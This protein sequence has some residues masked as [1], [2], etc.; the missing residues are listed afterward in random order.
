M[1]DMNRI[2]KKFLALKKLKQGALICYVVGGYPD[3]DTTREVIISLVNGGTDIIEIGIPFSD[4]IA[5][6]PV[7]QKA[8]TIALSNNITPESCLELA[9]SVRKIFP[10]LPLIFMTYSNILLRKGFEQ[11]MNLSKAAGIDGFIIPDLIIEEANDYLKIA[12]DLNLATIFLISPN[13][14]KE[15]IRRISEASKGFLYLVSVFGTTGL[16]KKFDDHTVAMIRLIKQVTDN[17]NVAVGFG[18][19]KQSHVKLMINSGADGVIVGSAIVNMIGGKQ[20]DLKNR[21]YSYA[22]LLKKSCKL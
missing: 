9:V 3:L 18:I 5:D 11:F 19:S 8:S 17:N 2:E 6:G 14:T 13:T 21:M 1:G 12:N 4:P 15:R 10:D 20:T 16:R 7:I 22:K